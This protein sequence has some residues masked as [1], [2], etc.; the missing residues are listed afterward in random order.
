MKDVII[1]LSQIIG[2]KLRR[3]ELAA[4]AVAVSVR[5]CELK[6]KEYQG[7]LARP[8]QL[9]RDIIER[10]YEIFREKHR[11]EKPLRSIYVRA[12]NLIPEEA[13]NA[14]LSL[15]MASEGALCALSAQSIKYAFASAR[16]PFT[17]RRTSPT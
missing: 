16:M 8:T 15:L 10:A 4:C 6:V 13:A 2:E 17:R 7:T 12:I 3:E 5:T 11:W 1:E 9:T 14:Q